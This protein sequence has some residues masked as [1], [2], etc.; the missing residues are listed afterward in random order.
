MNRP[1]WRW[2]VPLTLATWSLTLAACDDS[3]S[4]TE[5]TVEEEVVEV[6][7]VTETFP[8]D[9]ELGETSCHDFI[10]AQTG[11]VDMTI[12]AIAPLETLTVGMGIGT[13]D[14]AVEAGC[15]MFALDSS[16]RLGEIL[17]S[18]QLEA[19]E[20]CVCVYDVGNIFPSE[21]VTYSVD[22]THP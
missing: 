14:A 20:Y 6:A 15:V 9:L 1:S 22:V 3:T 5:P 18:P 11:D 21:T 10:T 13:P 8:G 17:Q 4:P 12:S 16:V 7:R 19:A 2:T